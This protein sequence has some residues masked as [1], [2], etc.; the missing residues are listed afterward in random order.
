[1]NR[2]PV[3]SGG[4]LPR[5]G[6]GLKWV[7]AIVGVVGILG[8][9]L[10]NWVGFADAFV[11]LLCAPEKVLHGQIWRL[12]TAGILTDPSRMQHLLFTIVGLYFLSTDLERR[13]GT[14]RFLVFLASSVVIGNALAILVYLIAPP[15]L[16]ILR[17]P[18]MFGAAAAITATAIAWSRA[19][20]GLQVLMFFV[21]PISGRT[22]FWVTIGFCI[23]GVIYPEAPEGVVAPFGG[24]LTGILMSGEPSPLRRAY[25]HAKLAFLRRQGGVPTAHDIAFG[26][27]P[28]KARRSGPP[29]RVVQGGQSDEPKDKR[30]LN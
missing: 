29:L 21:L 14:R 16:A 22:L 12:L 15:H 7:L 27:G 8:A 13:W 18:A 24:V 20:A 28:K 17:P 5:P 19:N 4:G 30:Y 10:S 26:K 9:I 23:L 6:P 1:M 25:L 11:A 2:G 3:L